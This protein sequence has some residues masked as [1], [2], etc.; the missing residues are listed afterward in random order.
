MPSHLSQHTEAQKESG[1]L[2][3]TVSGI[4]Y[5]KITN[6]EEKDEE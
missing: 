3:S 4:L 6:L 2:T 5:I 1:F